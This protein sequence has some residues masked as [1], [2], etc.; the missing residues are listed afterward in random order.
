MFKLI[1]SALFLIA[2][3]TAQANTEPQTNNQCTEYQT[4]TGIEFTFSND[5]V[6]R[7][8][9]FQ[10]FRE[11]PSELKSVPFD[12]LAGHHGKVIGGQLGP[13]GVVYFHKVL[14][15]NCLTVYWYDTDNVLEAE[16]ALPAAI[17]FIDKP[18]THWKISEEIDPMT[19]AKSCII[20]PQGADVYPI[21]VYSSA[22]GFFISVVGG[23][24]PGRQI[25]FRV[26]KNKNISQAEILTGARA[27]ILL[28]QIR[29]GGKQMI[30]KSYKWPSDVPDINEFNL[31]GLPAI[32]D[33]CRASIKK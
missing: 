6:F 21:F 9:G 24:F 30:V 5:E 20:S 19:D 1:L 22:N 12:I 7:Q 17:T 31:T 13:H 26:D 29:K 28:S 10:S 11:T 3:S 8:Y 14:V 2:S 16:D 4:S 32:L 27:Q 25:S 33:Q 18:L 15:D 23:D